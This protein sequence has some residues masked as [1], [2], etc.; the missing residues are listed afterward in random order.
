[1]LKITCMTGLLVLAIPIRVAPAQ[2]EGSSY[3]SHGSDRSDP[4]PGV[5][6]IRLILANRRLNRRRA[7]F[8]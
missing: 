7:V 3:S 8:D 4:L 5:P 6:K 1:M 2:G